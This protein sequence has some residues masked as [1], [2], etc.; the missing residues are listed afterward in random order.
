MLLSPVLLNN[1][2]YYFPQVVRISILLTILAEI[3][4]GFHPSGLIVFEIFVHQ[5][6]IEFGLLAVPTLGALT[7]SR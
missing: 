2:N 3:L 1:I 7:G 6:I 5:L 4:Q